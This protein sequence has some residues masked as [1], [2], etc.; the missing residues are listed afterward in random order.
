MILSCSSSAK[1]PQSFIPGKSKE[2]TITPQQR[3]MVLEKA[4]NLLEPKR[5]HMIAQFSRIGLFSRQLTTQEIIQFFYVSYNPEASEGQHIAD[6]N[7][8]TTPLVTAG[9]EGLTMNDIQQTVP[10]PPTEQTTTTQPAA[11]QSPIPT[12]PAIPPQLADTPVAS[13]PAVPE[14]P[15]IASEPEPATYT[16]TQ[17]PA[18]S[19]VANQ[20]T[21]TQ[22]APIPV[23]PTPVMPAVEVPGQPIPIAQEPLTPVEIPPEPITPIVKPETMTAQPPVAVPTPDLTAEKVQNEQSVQPVAPAPITTPNPG[24]TLDSIQGVAAVPKPVLPE[25]N[26]EELTPKQDGTALPPLPEI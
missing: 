2:S 21:A 24:P 23:P 3:T 18:T 26:S 10:Q 9:V 4:R 25:K 20:P 7:N 14:I 15:P 6:T 5:D 12:P 1:S 17:M 11:V 13:V 19:P 8:Y 22:P 16:P